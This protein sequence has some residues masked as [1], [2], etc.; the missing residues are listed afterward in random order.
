MDHYNP[1]SGLSYSSRPWCHISEPWYTYPSWITHTSDGNI[2]LRSLSWPVIRDHGPQGH[3]SF[4]VFLDPVYSPTC[5]D[6]YTSVGTGRLWNL[7]S[8]LYSSQLT[9]CVSFSLLR[10]NMK[11]GV[12]LWDHKLTGESTSTTFI[13]KPYPKIQE[14]KR[15][16]VSVLHKMKGTAH[17]QRGWKQ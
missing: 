2:Y 8:L 7:Y 3:C 14:N 9:V 11:F 15:H 16:V 5:A 12:W 6:F 17:F 1:H 4:M 13:S 10:P